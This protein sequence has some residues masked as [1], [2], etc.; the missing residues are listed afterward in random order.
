V[1]VESILLSCL[2]GLF[3]L[4]CE[5][6]L[7][8]AQQPPPGLQATLSSIQDNIFTPKCAISGCHQGTNASG[9]P[10]MSLEAGRARNNL[11][12]VTSRTYNKPRVTRGNANN[13]V[14]YL[15]VIGDNS[16]GARMPQVGAP[17]SQAETDTIKAWI[18]R[19][20]PD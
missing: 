2:A 20:T 13:S 1:V 14:L 15:K 9:N 16:V 5:H 8:V 12:N 6:E 7:P 19:N 10:P 3:F 17:L 4:S 11:V 18:N